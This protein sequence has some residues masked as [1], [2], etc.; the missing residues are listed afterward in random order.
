[1]V[2]FSAREAVSAVSPLLGP[3]SE[4]LPLDAVTTGILGMLPTAGFAV[5]GFLAPP[6]LRRIQLEHL[7]LASI[8]LTTLGQVGRA[9]GWNILAFLV[10]TWIAMLGIGVVNVVIP[11][12]LMKYF[13]DKTGI[14]ATLHITLLGAG[15]AVAAQSAIPLGNLYGWRFSI[16]I[17]AAVSAVAAMPWLILLAGQRSV[18]RSKTPPAHDGPSPPANAIKPWRSSIGWGAALIFAGC[19]SNTFA[20]LSWLPAVLVDRGMSQETAGSMLALYSILAVPVALIVPLVVVRMP[21]P[22]P[23]AILFVLAFAI[24]YGGIIF[25]PPASAVAWVVIAG[26][27]Q[28]VYS[29]AFTMINKRTRTQSGSGILSGFAQGVGYALASVGPFLFGLLHHPGDG[30]LPSFGMLGAWLAVLS[31]GAVMVNKPRLLEDAFRVAHPGANEA[32]N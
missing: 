4:D 5:M 32:R 24:G 26:L 31:V 21:R 23:V 17:W 29:F 6:L 25:A 14:L 30:W 18:A 2:A 22:L 7:L 8:L 11:P 12:L 16:G 19:S 3:I 15:T 1:M 10:F 27:G 9:L 28:G 20:A 13:P